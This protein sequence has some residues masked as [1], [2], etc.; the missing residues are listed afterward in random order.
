[1]ANT[2]HLLADDIAALATAL[3]GSELMR[4]VL[5]QV[6]VEAKKTLEQHTQR[7]LGSDM[8]FSGWKRAG[9]LATGFEF[10]GDNKIVFAPRNQGP[11]TVLNDGRHRG[12]KFSRRRRR[13]VGWGPTRGKNTWDEAWNDIERD[14]ERT[15][16]RE[17][18]DRLQDVWGR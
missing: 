16:E 12:N 4:D 5:T 13:N 17:L 18:M 15:M 6:G 9:K 11:W 3:G 2:I 10:E 7:D 1:M 14:A 8:R